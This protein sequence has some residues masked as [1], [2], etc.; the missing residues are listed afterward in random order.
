[1]KKEKLE[2]VKKLLIVVDMVN[3]FVREGVMASQNIEHIV[4]VVT[5]LV[6]KFTIDDGSLVAFIKDTHS[7]FAREFK[8]F[9]KHC[10]RG[11]REAENID[12]LKKYENISLV[13]E[14]N[15]TCA[16]F[17]KGFLDDINKM[18]KL[19]EIVICGCCTDICVINLAIPLDNYFDEF[20]KDIDIIISEDSVETYDS[21]NHNA[22]EYNEMAFKLMKQSGIKLVK[23]YGG[24]YE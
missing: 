22:K 16:I 20:N 10:V 5:N 12:E 17:A 11:T 24:K 21:E 19:K 15:S 6:N 3:G 7:E 18:K 23:R 2:N 8:K 9:P 1:M 14:K 4:P 13:Y